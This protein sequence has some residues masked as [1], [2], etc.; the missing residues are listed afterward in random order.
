M[1]RIDN[2]ILYTLLILSLGFSCVQIIFGLKEQYVSPSTDYLW[3]LVFA[4]LVAGWTL[5]EPKHKDFDAPFE[6]GAFVYFVWP[7]VLPYYL[8]KTRG[9]EGGVLFFGF[10]GL[11]Y[12]PFLSGLM[13]Y[14]FYT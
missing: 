12:L 13:A 3:M 14:V 7:L 9:S 11:Y 2:L 5:K 4:L 6:F 10:V 8:W 1:K